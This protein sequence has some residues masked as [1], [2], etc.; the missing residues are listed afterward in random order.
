MIIVGILSSIYGFFSILFGMGIAGWFENPRVLESNGVVLGLLYPIFA[1][2]T[3]N[4]P[5][6]IKLLMDVMNSS[7]QTD[8]NQDIYRFSNNPEEQIQ[9]LGSLFNQKAKMIQEIN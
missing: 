8:L 4:N 6:S 3:S 9:L 7:S 2:D 5:D 1:A